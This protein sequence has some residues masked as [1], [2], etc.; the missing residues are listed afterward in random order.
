MTTSLPVLKVGSLQ[1]FA[2][3]QSDPGIGKVWQLAT[4]ILFEQ[5]NNSTTVLPDVHLQLEMRDTDDGNKNTAIRDTV[6]FAIEHRVPAIFGAMYSGVSMPTSLVS[7]AWNIPQ[8]S[9]ISGAA[10]LSDKGEYPT[11]MRTTGGSA[12]EIVLM[13]EGFLKANNWLEVTY[14]AD[15]DDYAQSVR[16]Q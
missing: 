15:D 9:A 7:S 6:D 1:N 13:L 5:I 8:I 11:F 2:F 4:E 14:I 10:K 16:P 3:E 12:S